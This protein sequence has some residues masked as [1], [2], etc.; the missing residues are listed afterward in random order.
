MVDDKAAL[1]DLGRRVYGLAG[2]ALGVIGLI[3]RDF[4]AVWQPIENFV[5]ESNRA[6]FGPVFAVC[7]LAAGVATL[8]RRSAGAGLLALT[9][10]HFI[11]AL[12]WVPRILANLGIFPV[13]NG[14]FEQ[15]ALVAGGVVAYASLAPDTSA[16]KA[17]TVQIGCWLF[18]ICA[19]AFGVTHF[20]AIPETASFVP[21]WI[22]GPRFWAWATGV[23][24]LLAGIAILSGVMAVL[25]S[26]L[27]TAMMIGFGVLLW[28]PASFARPGDHFTWAGNAI[29]LA[30]VGAAW[31]IA[32]SIASRRKQI[33]SQLARPSADGAADMLA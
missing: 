1:H 15:L 33:R 4:A 9:T 12:A 10:L 22:P 5:G 17:R 25:A 11:S 29:N 30:L 21:K 26:R 8:W 19:V 14:L 16:W 20:T 6:L 32:D 23:F 31:V 24:H 2:I 18:G 7:F 3:W 28:A 27:L 13:W